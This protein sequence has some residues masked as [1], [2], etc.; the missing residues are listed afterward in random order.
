MSGETVI[1]RRSRQRDG[2]EPRHGDA[3]ALDEEPGEAA[4]GERGADRRRRDALAAAKRQCHDLRPRDGLARPDLV[5]GGEHPASASSCSRNT[6]L[7]VVE[8]AV[9]VE[10]DAHRI[11]PERSR[12][13]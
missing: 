13:P 3:A 8:R 1:C 6:R 11:A 5:L 12:A 9:G 7:A 4:A 2:E 10:N